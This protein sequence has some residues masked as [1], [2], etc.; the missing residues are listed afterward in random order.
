MSKP[1]VLLTGDDGYNSIG[2]RLV[3]RALHESCELAIAATKHQQS[4]VGGALSLMHGGTWGE[5]VVDGVPALWVDGTPADA[6]ECAQ[7]YFSHPFDALISGMN[8]GPNTSSAIVSSGTVS[9]LVRGMGVQIAPRGMALSWE[10]PLG[11]WYKSHDEKEDISSFFVYPGDAI[12]HVLALAMNQ[13]FWGAPM[14]NINLPAEPT[15][16]VRFTKI[17]KDITSC[18]SYPIAFDRQR[19]TFSYDRASF[20]PQ[21]IDTRYD[22]GAI[23]AG[24]ISIT[25][26]AFDITH[27]ATFARLEQTVLTLPQSIA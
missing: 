2:I 19:H 9:A 5:A 6:M 26:C 25:P 16:E 18:W 17:L 23:H 13:D 1:R 4:G 27:F 14:L 7:A 12:T 8:M 3:V 20:S 22:V 21:S 15:T 11:A 10:A 24:A